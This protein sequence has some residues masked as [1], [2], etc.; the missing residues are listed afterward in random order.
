MRCEFFARHGQQQGQR[1]RRA[2]PPGGWLLCWQQ[3]MGDGDLEAG[4]LRK[5]ALRAFI[6]ALC[7]HGIDAA[8][9]LQLAGG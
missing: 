5:W 9:S 8:L 6:V 1:Q 2:Q 3:L 7:W 4:G